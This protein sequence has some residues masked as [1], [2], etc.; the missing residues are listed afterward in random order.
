MYCL[1]SA[2]RKLLG[3]RGKLFLYSYTND[4]ECVFVFS[5]VLWV[6]MG[7]MLL[8]VLLLF[9]PTASCNRCLGISIGLESRLLFF[10]IWS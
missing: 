7:S 3:V 8:T 6:K 10:L 1:C 2:R 9:L 4:N 5:L